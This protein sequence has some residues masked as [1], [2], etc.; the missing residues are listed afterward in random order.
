MELETFKG[1]I[2]DADTGKVIGTFTKKATLPYV[3]MTW[4]GK[5]DPEFIHES[6]I[7]DDIRAL[8][9]GHHLD[10]PYED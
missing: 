3:V 10:W 9:K 6:T 1:K 8:F 7:L 4:N 2:L 5:A